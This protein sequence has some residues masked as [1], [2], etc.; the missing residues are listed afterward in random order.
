MND[1][2]AYSFYC[3]HPIPTEAGVWNQEFQMPIKVNNQR[4]FYC[5]SNTLA[6]RINPPRTL[7]TLWIN[8]HLLQ[9]K[10]HLGSILQ[11]DLFCRWLHWICHDPRSVCWGS[12]LR[13]SIP[14]VTQC[15]LALEGGKGHTLLSFFTCWHLYCL[16][17]LQR[18]AKLSCS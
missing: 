1:Q 6:R 2:R 5:V 13:R 16:E 14:N 7:S 4:L 12:A 15:T 17:R 3:Q 11:T 10:A 18:I 9:S 8:V